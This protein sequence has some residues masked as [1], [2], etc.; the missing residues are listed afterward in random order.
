M[1]ND[2]RGSAQSGFPR[3]GSPLASVSDL[4]ANIVAADH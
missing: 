2:D 4:D 1:T 3:L